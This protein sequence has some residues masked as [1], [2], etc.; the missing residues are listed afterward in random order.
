MKHQT[1][2]TTALQPA[3]DELVVQLPSQPRLN[4]DESPTKEGTN[5]SWLWTFVAATFTVFALRGS[6][7]ATTITELLGTTFAGVIGCD[8]AKMYWQCGRLQWFWAHLKRGPESEYRRHSS[9]VKT[10]R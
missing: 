3:Y 1:I 6:R 2:T 7:A 8:R 10:E 5:K 4:G 9:T